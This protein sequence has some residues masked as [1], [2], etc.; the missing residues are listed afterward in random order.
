M[1]QTGSHQEFMQAVFQSIWRACHRMMPFLLVLSLLI[2]PALCF[3]DTKAP[4]SN[5]YHKQGRG[6]Y[7]SIYWST[8]RNLGS[9]YFPNTDG[10]LFEELQE[11]QWNSDANGLIYFYRPDSQWASEEL[12]APSYYINDELVFNLR[13][14]SYTYVELPAGSYDFAV[15]KSLLPLIGFEAFDDKLMMAFDLNLQADIGL[16]IDPGSVFYIRHSEV[17][18]PAKLHP[19]LDPDDEMAKADVQLVDREMAMTEI[20]KT[21]YLNYSFWHPTDAA[22]AEELLSGEMQEYGWFTVIWPWS[23]NFL[24]GFPFFYLP[25][26]MYREL[27]GDVPLTIEQELY[28]LADDKEAYLE[29]IADKRT[30][31]RNWLAPWRKPSSGLTLN[32]ELLLDR[33]ERNALAGNIQPAVR[34]EVVK[35]VEDDDEVPWYWPFGAKQVEVPAEVTVQSKPVDEVRQANIDRIKQSLN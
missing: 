20:D 9:Y 23:N 33:L 26:D 35:E 32:D 14:G 17:S 31:K 29:A 8:G 2:V 15:R 27:R 30:I 21:R 11:G 16:E 18:L 12:E 22:Q 7:P 10:A 13:A 25:S 24:F 3:A 1:H 4:Y 5:P 34:E 19:D 6:W 28:L